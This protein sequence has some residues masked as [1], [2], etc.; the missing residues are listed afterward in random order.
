MLSPAD[1]DMLFGEV[2][3]R[4]GRKAPPQRQAR[5]PAGSFSLLLVPAPVRPV[6]PL[7][8]RP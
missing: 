1:F 7:R 8:F 4:A 5:H 2:R 6:R 3:A